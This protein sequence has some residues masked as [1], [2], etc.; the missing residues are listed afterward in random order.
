MD[1]R[2]LG[3]KVGLEIHQQ[4]ATR[5]LFCECESVLVDE[6]GG[7]R[8]RRRSRPREYGMGEMDAAAPEGAK[9]RLP[10]VYGG[11]PNSCLV[12]AHDEPPHRPNPAGQDAAGH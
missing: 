8:L 2:A 11:T 7:I 1:Y 6:P 4:R 9:R 5:K 10:S 12:E 3:L